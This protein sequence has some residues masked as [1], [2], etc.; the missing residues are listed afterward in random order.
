[1]SI[2]TTIRDIDT[3]GA[4][5]LTPD[6]GEI[7]SLLL[8]VSALTARGDVCLDLRELYA[9]ERLADIVTRLERWRHVGRPGGYRPLILEGTRLYLHRFHAFEERVAAA[10]RRLAGIRHPIDTRRVRGILDRLFPPHP[11][12]EIDQQRRAAATAAVS[13]LLILSGGPGTGKTTTVLKILALLLEIDPTLR[14][15]LAAPTGKAANRL[16]ESIATGLP[17]LPEGSP[18]T[19]IPTD[20]VTIHRLLGVSPDGSS[21]RHHRNAPLPVDLLVIDEASMV[22]LP[23]M[24]KVVDA[25]PPHCRLVLIGDQ[26]QLASVDPGSLLGE[27]CSTPAPGM[28]THGAAPIL[29]ELVG[30]A[31]EST[32]IRSPLVDSLV[33]LTRTYRFGGES[34]IGHLS[35]AIIEG[36]ADT[37]LEVLC[38][39][40]FPDCTLVEGF[41]SRSLGELLE[42]VVTD[43][44]GTFRE[45]EGAEEILARFNR[46]RIL[47][48]V[49]EGEFGTRRLNRL[50]EETLARRGVIHPDDQW[51]DGRVILVTENDHT[52]HLANGDIGIVL[53]QDGV[54]SLFVATQGGIR[55]IPLSLPPPH[56]TA[57]AMTVHKSQGSEFDR[58]VVIIPPGDSPLLSVELLYTAVTRGKR[59]VDLLCSEETL[60][61]CCRRR[62]GR[63]SGLGEK[64][65]REEQNGG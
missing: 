47:C 2:D 65:W 8:T 30:G 18:V 45:G 20:A 39:D 14:V 42:P 54:R 4:D 19:M 38:S 52:R 58:V 22:S 62:V 33:I 12:G 28:V 31:L 49:R 21:I 36:D 57:F 15:R 6:D 63:R 61:L 41:P 11:G 9:D 25:L 27:I 29:S 32:P 13:S 3:H 50:V 48:A 59:R 5:L 26:N 46:F 37:A 40:R 60:R 35:R 17:G 56:E 53:R 51:Y 64:V 10:L 24:A 55:P 16:S 34:G 44:Y 1:M 7:R 23:L 43:G